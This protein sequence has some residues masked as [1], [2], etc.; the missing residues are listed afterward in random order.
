MI[1]HVPPMSGG[2]PA[3]TVDPAFGVLGH[4]PRRLRSVVTLTALARSRSRR[5]TVLLFV[6]FSRTIAGLPSSS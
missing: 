4:K 2:H 3:W 5:V 6:K 1:P